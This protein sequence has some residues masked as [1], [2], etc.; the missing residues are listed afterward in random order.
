MQDFLEIITPGTFLE[1][2]FGFII[3][4]FIFYID[5]RGKIR[6]EQTLKRQD[7]ALDIILDQ[8]SK[9]NAFQTKSLSLAITGSLS[10]E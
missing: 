6:Q 9:V 10:N 1:I 4:I 7:D 3:S 2:L 5:S 8:V